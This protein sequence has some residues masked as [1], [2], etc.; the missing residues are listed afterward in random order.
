MR[1]LRERLSLYRKRCAFR[2]LGRLDPPVG[3][4]AGLA[5]RGGRRA[6]ERRAVA[7]PPFDPRAHRAPPAGKR[8]RPPPLARLPTLARATLRRRYRYWTRRAS[9]PIVAVKCL[10]DRSPLPTRVSPPL[11]PTARAPG[12]R[13][14]CR[15]FGTH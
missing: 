4:S 11:V 1:V 12:Y 13:H 6:R 5:P 14:R 2:Y 8:R 15:Q 7:G 10:V 9:G 3:A